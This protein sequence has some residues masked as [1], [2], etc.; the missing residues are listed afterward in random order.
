MVGNILAHRTVD[1]PAAVELE[2]IFVLDGVVLLL[3]RIQQRP[4]IADYFGAL[5]DRFGGEEAKPGAGTANA[6]GFIRGNGRDDRYG[7]DTLMKATDREAAVLK[8]FRANVRCFAQ[9]P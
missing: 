2:Q 8:R 5:L 6:I 1:G 9:S 4:K 7:T 3:P